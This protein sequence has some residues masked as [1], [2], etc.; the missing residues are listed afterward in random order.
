[1]PIQNAQAVN[2]AAKFFP[3]TDEDTKPCIEVAG[4]QVYAYVDPDGYLNVSVDLDTVRSFMLTDESGELLVPIRFSV[5][6]E[7]AWCTSPNGTTVQQA[8]LIPPGE[9]LAWTS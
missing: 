6:G 1:M 3:Q 4:A 8:R 9:S 5:N 7:D 2:M